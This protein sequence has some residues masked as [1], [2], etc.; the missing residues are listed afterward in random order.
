M[1]KKTKKMSELASNIDPATGVSK[2]M[3]LKIEQFIIEQR[4][5]KEQVKK[6]KAA[7]GALENMSCEDIARTQVWPD[8]WK[9]GPGKLGL[10]PVTKK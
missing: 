9:K 2:K 6:C 1:A 8:K 7:G 3:D 10:R 5:F 4:A